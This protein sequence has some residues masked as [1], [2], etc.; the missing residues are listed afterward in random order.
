MRWTV[1]LSVLAGCFSPSA[2][3]GLPCG[4]GQTC[5][6]GQSCD[7]V[8][9]V[10]GLPSAALLWREDTADELSAGSGDVTIEPL[11]FLSPAAYLTGVIRVAG[12]DGLHSGEPFEVVAA[13][14]RTG[15]AVQRSLRIDYQATNPPGLG[16]ADPDNATV[17]ID[18]EI[19]LEAAGSWRFELTANDRGYFEIAPPGGEFERIVDDVDTGTIGTFV[20]SQPGWH[21]FRAAFEDAAQ[22]L[23]YDLVY[24]PPNVNG[25]AFR[26]IP[27]DRLRVRF[28]GIGDGLVVDGFEHA[29][30]IDLDGTI[31]DQ[32]PLQDVVLDTNPFELPIGTGFTVRWSGQFLI[33]E[34]GDYTFAIK[35][36]NGHRLF[37]DGAALVDELNGATGSTTESV[38]L[39]AGWHDVVLDVNKGG[40]AETLSLIVQSGPQFA[41]GPLPS[42]HLRP[43]IGRGARFVADQALTAVALP[44]GT[45]VAGSRSLTLDVPGT[46]VTARD[47]RTAIELTGDDLA[48]VSLV[49]DPP[50]GANIP[51]VGVGDLTGTTAFVTEHL[52]ID[53]FGTNWLFVGTDTVANALT[54]EI[55]AAFLTLVYDGGVAPFAVS[56]R[57][58]SA[59]REL[60]D[61][62]AFERVAWTVRGAADAIKV[63]LRTCDAADC[64]GEDYVEVTNSS[65]PELAPKRFAQ[66][67]VE[68]ASDGDTSP[69]LD[70]FELRYFVRGSE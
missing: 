26:A 53:T 45:G 3:E 4:E 65:V 28:D 5:P 55:S 33:D 6:E 7:L 70:A 9:N 37:I 22:A 67:R 13:G 51:V 40:P 52:P 27:P 15:V 39:A 41:G 66:Y 19:E 48:S 12:Y 21:R 68:I 46:F 56:S 61:A 10:C 62:I 57:Y 1:A 47:L 38:T 32:T 18:G 43:V 44:D 2:P 11:G 34:P 29:N 30:L 50:A 59:V 69:A 63:S 20:V 42:D 54:D 14:P 24:D 25:A 58:E 64:A 60:G 23:D 36:P 49:I 31:I 35:S 8:S 17:L 16:L